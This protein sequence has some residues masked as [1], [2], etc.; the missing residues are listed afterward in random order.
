MIATDAETRRDAWERRVRIIK[1][2]I[3]RVGRLHSVLLYVSLKPSTLP[4]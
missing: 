4:R 1:F 3:A 2:L